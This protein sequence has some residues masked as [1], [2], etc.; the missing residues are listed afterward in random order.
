LKLIFSFGLEHKGMTDLKS[1][2]RVLG[3]IKHLDTELF[4]YA[5]MRNNA[6]R[7]AARKVSNTLFCQHQTMLSSLPEQRRAFWP[8][9]WTFDKA[10]L[11]CS[12]PTFMVSFCKPKVL[13]ICPRSNETGLPLNTPALTDSRGNHCTSVAISSG[14][15]VLPRKFSAS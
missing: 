2:P 7:F 1:V 15:F 3:Q 8:C 13:R 5:V 6:I 9:P 4:D 10:A 14:A 11:Y 12:T